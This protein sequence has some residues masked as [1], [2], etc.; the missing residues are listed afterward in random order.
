[1]KLVESLSVIVTTVLNILLWFILLPLFGAIIVTAITG[2]LLAFI[3]SKL[4]DH[5]DRQRATIGDT[6]D[7]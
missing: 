2:C 7:K 4:F 1:M 5:L 6:S 3:I